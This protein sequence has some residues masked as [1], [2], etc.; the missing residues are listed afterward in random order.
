[1]PRSIPT[2][3][4]AKYRPAVSLETVQVVA[5]A[6]FGIER[7]H[8]IASPRGAGSCGSWRAVGLVRVQFMRNVLT[9]HLDFALVFARLRG[10]TQAA[11]AAT[12]LPCCRKPWSDG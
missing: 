7:D 8:L 3:P 11:S 12:F 4:L 9:A 1:M 6:A 5:L 2:C 10:H